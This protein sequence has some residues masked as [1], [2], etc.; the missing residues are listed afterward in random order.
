MKQWKKWICIVCGFVYEEEYGWPE[1]GIPPE[2]K[3]EDVPNDWLCP[4]CGVG[5]NDF[6]MQERYEE[7]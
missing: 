6:V 7:Q 2:T 3:W 1:D 4:D 5:K